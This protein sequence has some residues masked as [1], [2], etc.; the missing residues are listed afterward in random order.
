MISGWVWVFLGEDIGVQNPWLRVQGR[1]NHMEVRVKF[2]VPTPNYKATDRDLWLEFGP[3]TIHNLAKSPSAWVNH[4][5]CNIAIHCAPHI[6]LH[7]SS[8][9]NQQLFTRVDMSDKIY[10]HHIGFNHLWK[11]D[12]WNWLKN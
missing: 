12:F 10:D 4:D 2:D 7:F 1:A 8:G 5:D 3:P 11:I 9:K 6:L